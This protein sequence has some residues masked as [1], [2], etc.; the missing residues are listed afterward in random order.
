MPQLSATQM[1]AVGPLVDLIASSL[2]KDR[3]VHAETAIACAARLAGALLLRSFDFALT[4]MQPG[5]VLLS[6]NANAKGPELISIVAM[7]ISRFGLVV[8]PA[9]AS[10]KGRG[11]DPQITFLDS[12]K[13]LQTRAVEICANHS[14]SF[15]QG[16]QSAA[17]ATGF[18]LKECSRSIDVEVAFN[19]AVYGIIEGSKTVPPPLE[20][21]LK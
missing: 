17:V 20:G 5:S 3:T 2:G 1:Q 6:E 9:S 14:L 21:T 11:H 15:E 8:D 16:A 13:L 4:D 18:I 10:R 19:V 7:T 12:L